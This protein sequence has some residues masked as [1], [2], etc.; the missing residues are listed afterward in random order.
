MMMKHKMVLAGL[1]SA[2]AFATA[3]AQADYPV[4]VQSCG[5]DLT[6]Q[7]APTRAVAHDMNISEMMFALDLQPSMVGLTGITGWYKMTPEFKQA[8]GDLPELAPKSPSMENLL[9]VSP[10]FLF[11]GWYYGMKPGG[12]VTPESLAEYDV[13]VYVLSESCA[14]LNKELP[15][16]SM[17]LL[18]Q[19]IANLGKIFDREKEADALIAGYQKRIA[20]VT[21]KTA[22]LTER[23]RVFLFDSGEE[24]PFTS[25]KFAMP[26]AIIEAAG[27]T[28]IM[29]D[30][31]ASWG[32]VSWESVV[33]RNPEFIVLVGYQDGSWKNR[34]QF[35][36]DN[37]ATA[38]IDAVKNDRFLVLNYTEITPG[39]NNIP[40]VEKLARALNPALF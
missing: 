24:K 16:A 25:G 21:S 32:R 19:D 31:E 7:A 17:D 10:D 22:S 23:A 20:M 14:H 12:E 40:A 35:L 28:N 27:G 26:S 11:A 38:E 37:P 15:K 9:N 13:P 18:Y 30:V 8:M 6:F 39:P 29:D 2:L 4:T 3:P 34:W 33:D 1:V 36:K 5:Q